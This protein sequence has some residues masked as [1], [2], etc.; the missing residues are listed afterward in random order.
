MAVNLIEQD[1]EFVSPWRNTISSS[2]VISL[3]IFPTSTSSRSLFSMP[4]IV[5]DGFEIIYIN[6]DQ[7]PWGVGLAVIL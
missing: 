7:R 3:R 6:I 1:D 2:F 5:V 4:K